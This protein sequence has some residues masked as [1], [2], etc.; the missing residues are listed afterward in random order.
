MIHGQQ[1][2]N[3]NVVRQAAV[4]AVRLDTADHVY[5]TRFPE[6]RRPLV[7]LDVYLVATMVWFMESSYIYRVKSPGCHCD[8]CKHSPAGESKRLRGL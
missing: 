7:K 6:I 2:G 8:C 5:E 3:M 1:A 4:D